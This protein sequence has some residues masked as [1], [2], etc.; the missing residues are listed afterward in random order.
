M[1]TCLSLRFYQI[2]MGWHALSYILPQAQAL[3]AYFTLFE[4][5]HNKEFYEY[6]PLTKF[7]PKLYGMARIVVLYLPHA[8]RGITTAVELSSDPNC[9][10]WSATKEA[11]SFGIE[12]QQIISISSWSF[13]TKVIPSVVRIRNASFPCLSWKYK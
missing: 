6:L 2:C 13:K 9:K 4:V 8:P 5:L 3:S 1:N 7:L 10:A 11:A 12:Q